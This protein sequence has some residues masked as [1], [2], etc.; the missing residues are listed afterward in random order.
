MYIDE[1]F[2]WGVT[3]FGRYYFSPEKNQSIYARS[4]LGLSHYDSFYVNLSLGIG[5][6]WFI[7]KNVGIEAELAGMTDF[8]D[9]GAGLFIG[10]QIYFN[11]P[12]K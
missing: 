12:E 9:F 10:F 2:A 4:S 11:S 1:E 8:S 6:V 3:P 7:N 5:N